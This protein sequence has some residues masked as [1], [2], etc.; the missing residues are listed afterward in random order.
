[1]NYPNEPGAD[2]GRQFYNPPDKICQS[3]SY[4]VVNQDDYGT[5]KDGTLSDD[6]CWRCY[7]DGK[8]T[9]RS[10]MDQFIEH[11]LP[12]MTQYFHDDKSAE[13][14]LR[15]ILPTLKRWRKN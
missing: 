1:V 4:P 12:F 2:N 3:C 14:Y 7:K 6:Y 5:E 15:Q 11:A 8:F 9:N 10:S 13:K